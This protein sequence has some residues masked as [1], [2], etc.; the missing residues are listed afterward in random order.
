M[1]KGCSTDARADDDDV[2]M[3][4]HDERWSVQDGRPYMEQNVLVVFSAFC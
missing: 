2:E 4:V 1:W 3:L